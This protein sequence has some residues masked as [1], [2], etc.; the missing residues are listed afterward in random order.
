MVSR[1]LRCKLQEN[2]SCRRGRTVVR[3]ISTKIRCGFHVLKIYMKG[4]MFLKIIQKGHQCLGKKF[5]SS[6]N[7]RGWVQSETEA[8]PKHPELVSC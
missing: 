5:A 8:S 2:F 3:G 4:D 7:L 1:E 6:S